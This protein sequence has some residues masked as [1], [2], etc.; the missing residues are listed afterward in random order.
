MEC[1][2]GIVGNT[3]PTK[4]GKRQTPAFQIKV[5]TICRLD[6]TTLSTSQDWNEKFTAVAAEDQLPYFF[7]IGSFDSYNFWCSDNTLEILEVNTE[8]DNDQ[9]QY[10]VKN[11]D[12]LSPYPAPKPNG[13][14]LILDQNVPDVGVEEVRL[15]VTADGGSSYEVSVQVTFI[16]DCREQ[17]VDPAVITITQRQRKLT[18][19]IDDLDFASDIQNCP[20]EGLKLIEEQPSE[21]VDAGISEQQFDDDLELIKVENHSITIDPPKMNQHTSSTIFIRVEVQSA[22][23]VEAK[24]ILVK[25]DTSLV[26]G[27]NFGKTIELER[28]SIVNSQQNVTIY[29]N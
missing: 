15:K 22:T 9:N 4:A 12:E 11:R 7:E 25:F 6:S 24:P 20:V 8:T 21:S 14:Y 1:E 28:L 5:D 23:M 27:A 19:T 13:V 2:Y 10:T 17:F 18:L 29:A 16:E 26:N 3:D